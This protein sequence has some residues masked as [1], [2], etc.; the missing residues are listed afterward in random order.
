VTYAWCPS[1]VWTIPTWASGAYTVSIDQDTGV[2]TWPHLIDTHGLYHLCVEISAN[3]NDPAQGVL[4][5]TDFRV[6][7]QANT[8]NPPSVDLSPYGSPGA[9]SM[10]SPFWNGVYIGFSNELSL[11]AEG[12]NNS[13]SRIDIASGFRGP[14][15]SYTLDQSNGSTVVT[16]TYDP[17]PGYS[18][19][20]LFCFQA[21]DSVTL[22]T[23]SQ[24]CINLNI[25]VDAKP[26]ISARASTF[27]VSATGFRLREGQQLEAIV[28]GFKPADQDNVTI[29]L[30]TDLEG[31]NSFEQISVG[32]N[33]SSLFQYTPP[34]KYAGTT[35]AACFAARGAPGP[36]RVQEE[37]VTCL[38]IEIERCV[39]TIKEGE[40]LLSMAQDLGMSWLQL[41]NYN[42]MTIRKPDQD[43]LAGSGIRVG[44]L[45]SVQNGDSLY[46]IAERYSTSVERLVAINADL[47][48]ST[49][50]QVG[51]SIC[52]SFDSCTA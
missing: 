11:S 50:L 8:T 36:L 22:A 43:L 18:G 7:V 38:D 1:S 28:N 31:A 51:Q 3:P 27:Q 49:L 48:E 6:R 20:S 14:G 30:K 44:Q 21:R 19:W 4:S 35:Q 10:L 25:T 33:A 32:H 16:I 24:A 52:V 42:K 15:S 29:Y 9:F 45:Y 39:W 13:M 23:S 17:L 46:N 34:R 12:F 47:T 26:F 40:S 5:Q 37:A 41:W 2:V